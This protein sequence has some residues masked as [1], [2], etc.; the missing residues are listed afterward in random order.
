MAATC[1][2]NQD[3]WLSHPVRIAGITREIPG[4]LTLDFEFEDSARA[5]TW[6]F[7]P[8]QFT[9]LYVPGVGES[10]ISISGDAADTG[11]IRQTIRDA[12]NVTHSLTG[13]PI[14]ATIGLRGPFGSSWPVDECRGRDVILVAGGI[15]LAPLRPVIY[16]MLHHRQQYQELTLI[17]GA[18]EPAL[19]LYPGEFEH[20]RTQG[21]NIIP[22]VDHADESW[23]GGV[24]VVTTVLE[25]LWLRSPA[26]TMLMTCGP[27]VMMWYTMQTALGRGI[28]A[29][30]L[31]LSMERNMNCAIALCGHCQFGPYFLCREGPVFRFEQLR[32]ILR[33]DDL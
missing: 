12:G 8:G 19:L 1:E 28:P 26:E 13:L 5:A 21:L 14:G 30:S 20:W 24:G 11:R 2:P 23:R 18:R 25:R 6:A 32:S 29:G 15:G 31:F 3:P 22:T 10:A 16:H 33:I 4:V 9:M 17:V 27:E 7:R